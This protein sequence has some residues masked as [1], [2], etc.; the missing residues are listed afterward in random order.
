MM[1]LGKQLIPPNLVVG[2]CMTDAGAL[3][4]YGHPL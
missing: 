1:I 2:E 4:I 3:Y